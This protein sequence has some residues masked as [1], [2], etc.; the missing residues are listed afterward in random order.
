MMIE[1]FD[2]LRSLDDAAAGAVTAALESAVRRDGTASLAATGGRMPGPVYDL[3][4]VTPLEWS[5]VRVTL[6]DER[7]VDPSSPDSNERLVRERLLQHRAA[8][9][10]FHPL[11]AREPSPE[12]A[13]EHASALFRSW[14][15]LDVVMLGMGEDGHVASLFPGSPALEQGLDPAAPACIVVPAGE[16]RPPAQARLSL[17]IRGLTTAGLV[18]ILASGQAKRA[19][20]ERALE[21]GDPHELPVCAVLQSGR[22]VRILWTA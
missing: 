15:P 7:W 5:R 14:P 8:G 17:T 11:R 9:A 21:G 12:A 22:P 13:A 1:A 20:L 18:V 16:G 2:D 6:T 3:M 10:V 19:V 4:A